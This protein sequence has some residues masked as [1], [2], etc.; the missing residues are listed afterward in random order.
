MPSKWYAQ[1]DWASERWLRNDCKAGPPRDL[2]QAP[3]LPLDFA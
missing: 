2:N 3:R 1:R